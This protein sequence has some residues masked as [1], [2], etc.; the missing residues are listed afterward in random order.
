MGVFSRGLTKTV[1]ETPTGTR[2][3]THTR[4]VTTVLILTWVGLKYKTSRLG[5]LEFYTNKPLSRKTLPSPVTN[6]TVFLQCA[7]RTR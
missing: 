2:C 1:S 4:Q 5:T 3:G 7:T 6:L